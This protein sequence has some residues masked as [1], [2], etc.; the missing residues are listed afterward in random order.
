MKY[1]F[2]QIVSANLS[3][4]AQVAGNAGVEDLSPMDLA[5][6][7]GIIMIPI[8]VLFVIAIFLLIERYLTIR[9]AS[10]LDATFMASIK[11]MVMN[12]NLIGAVKLCEK[13]DTP[14]SR[15][16]E[17]GL[18]RIGKPLKS[19]EV[20]IEN[21][22]KLELYKLEKGLPFM[23][24]ISGAAPMIGF[25]GTVTGMIRALYDLS[26]KGDT[27]DAGSLS[28]G[29]YEAMVT[30]VAGLVV[31]I[32]AYLSYNILT[33]MIEKVVYKMEASSVEFFDILQ[34]PAKN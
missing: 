17:K 22:G 2:L 16:I 7:G 26:Q 10:K 6:K 34:Q 4:T 14:I 27:I 13:T 32:I 20:A 11:D 31:G 25:L 1:N 33:T 5:I 21:I 23:A 28:G 29:I 8:V 30:T 12:D 19:I 15:M 24:T 9:K 18:S 3:D